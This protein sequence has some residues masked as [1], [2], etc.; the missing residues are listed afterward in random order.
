LSG[1]EGEA[2]ES[3]FLG[4]LTIAVILLLWVLSVALAALCLSLAPVRLARG[5]RWMALDV[6]AGSLASNGWRLF[7]PERVQARALRA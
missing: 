5:V 7:L 3:A 2:R 1:P 6:M 4:A